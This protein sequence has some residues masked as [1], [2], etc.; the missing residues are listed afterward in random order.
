MLFV[1]INNPVHR[2]TSG[3]LFC[4]LLFQITTTASC[5]WTDDFHDQLSSF[6]GVVG[7][8]LT[9]FFQHEHYD[10]DPDFFFQRP[11]T[12][13]R[14]EGRAKL[15]LLREF[16]HRNEQRLNRSTMQFG[17]ISKHL[18]STVS[19]FHSAMMGVC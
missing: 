11:N 18:N 15:F 8:T 14:E 10:G 19:V 2:D 6:P 9:V 7:A 16:V 17:R 3:G 1:R 13:P 4:S 5:I 12:D